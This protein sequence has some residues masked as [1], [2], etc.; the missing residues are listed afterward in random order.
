MLN[1]DFSFHARFTKSRLVSHFTSIPLKRETKARFKVSLPMK[2]P[3]KTLKREPH[4]LTSFV[5][6]VFSLIS[7]HFT[8]R[9][10]VGA[11]QTN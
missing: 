9:F 5:S 3:A 6:R 7:P 1:P 2:R 11:L 10:N 4:L 8:F